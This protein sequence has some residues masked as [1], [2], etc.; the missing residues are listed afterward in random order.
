MNPTHTGNE[1]ETHGE[2]YSYQIA[3]NNHR[4]TKR[5]RSDELTGGIPVTSLE[6]QCND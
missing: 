6:Y 3:I 4:G 2:G 1:P 5:L